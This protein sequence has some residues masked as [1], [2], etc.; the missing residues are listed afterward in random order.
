MAESW[1]V[2]VVSLVS[3][4]ILA[5]LLT[6]EDF[7][8]VALAA[9]YFTF[10]S[11]FID[12]GFSTSLVQREELEDAHLDAVF[13][14]QCVLGVALAALTFFLAD[15][16]ARL[17]GEPVLTP[18]LQAL[19]IV[20]II[21]GLTLVQQA[22]LRRGLQF[23]GL[24]TRRVLSTAAGAAIAIVLA[25][26]G[27]GVWSLVAQTAGAALVSLVVFWRVSTWRPRLSFSFRH[28][29]DLTSFGAAVFAHDVISSIAIHIDRLLVGR[30]AG[31]GALGVY[32]VARRLDSI[33][34]E[35][36]VVGLQ[37]I[38]VPVFARVQNDRL[39]L[40]RGLFRAHRLIAFVV[41]PAFVGIA[42]TAPKLV[43]LLLGSKWIEA[44][45][46]VQ[47][48]TLPSLMA[49]LGFFLG[50]VITAIGRAGLRLAISI[51]HAL[52]STVLVLFALRWGPAAVA[53]AMG[54]AAMFSYLLN[55]V[56]LRRLIRLKLL[57]YHAQ[58][59]PAAAGTAVMAA[60]I[61]WTDSYLS[62]L[63]PWMALAL[64]IVTGA[65]AYVATT[66]ILARDQWQEI[67]ALAR[68]LNGDSKRPNA[69]ASALKRH[70]AE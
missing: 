28:L 1:L 23:R 27:F 30:F 66:L 19:S 29:R 10:G 3:F 13:W 34:G 2:R 14:A 67:I 69:G 26:Q 37:K 7:G 55:I 17:L 4:F 8:L 18:V 62:E 43:P 16:I 46:V 44:I 33:A 5:H 58:A 40:Q 65:L 59:W 60:A 45:P 47:A 52:V 6:P 36:L 41:L 50:N 24:A 15:P 61:L 21:S 31:A 32:S 25:T 11:F 48:A 49:A 70:P 12:Q 9:V 57:A 51:A 53:L 38:V 35:V 68:S 63:A 64:N 54:L 56:A 20:P 39:A 42:L 22:Q